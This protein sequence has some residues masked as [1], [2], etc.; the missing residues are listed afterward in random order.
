M[1]G[2]QECE[3]HQQDKRV[4]G[5][6]PMRRQHCRPRAAGAS[7]PRCH[8]TRH[9]RRSPA[10]ACVAR[11]RQQRTAAARCRHALG[12]AGCTQLQ[13]RARASAPL[14]LGTPCSPAG[15]DGQA[16]RQARTP[17]RG[18][19]PS[20]AGASRQR[21]RGGRLVGRSQPINDAPA[22]QER[23]HPDRMVGK[24]VSARGSSVSRLQQSQGGGP[25]HECS[26]RGRLAGPRAPG[27]W[28]ARGHRAPTS[29]A[30]GGRTGS[31][32]RARPPA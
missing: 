21:R 19:G 5:P 6:E 24:A 32:R 25:A 23:K 29:P 14:Q 31:W 28:P 15:A 13:Q 26:T 8:Q 18:G 7:Q 9:R 12:S 3:R 27:T 17:L 4:A 16:C 11:H 1:G 20:Q 30:R 22:L 2:G 10:A